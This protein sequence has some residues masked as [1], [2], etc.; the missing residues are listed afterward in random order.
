MMGFGDKNRWL[1]A[2]AT[3]LLCLLPAVV[4]FAAEETADFHQARAEAAYLAGDYARA[5]RFF[6][7]ALSADPSRTWNLHRQALCAVHLEQYDKAEPL[8]RQVLTRADARPDAYFDLG[9]T[10]YHLRRYREALVQFTLARQKGATIETIDYYRGACL[11]RTGQ[12]EAALEAL[13]AAYQALPERRASI[14]YY[15]GACAFAEERYGGAIEYWKEAYE[16]SE[17]GPF[18]TNIERLL[19]RARE[20]HRRTRLWDATVVFGGAWDS[21]V[22]YEPEEFEVADRSGFY[23]F[24]AA[25]LALYALRSR[26]GALGAGYRFY[27]S[28]HVDTRE[29]LLDDYDL[30]RHGLRLEAM[31][32]LGQQSP[33]FLGGEY[34]W[35]RAMLAGDNY[36]ESNAIRPF[37]HLR[38]G[39]AAATRLGLDAEWKSFDEYP[40]R[41]ALYLSPAL[42]QI[43]TFWNQTATLLLEASYENN[44]AETDNYDYRGFG[45]FASLELPLVG[46]LTMLTGL[47]GRYLDYQN[48]VE[49]R[50]DRKYVVDAGLRYHF[51]DWLYSSLGYR[52][53]NNVSLEEFTYEKHV[54]QLDIGFDF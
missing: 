5:Y 20:E 53:Q 46:S 49:E 32:R 47:R 39:A 42:T 33:L 6:E 19:R 3:L 18:R 23:W 34:E 48:N 29:Q 1:I 37:L 16:L 43:F 44:A 17:P 8:L 24:A 54:Y 15:Q 35:S 27:Q 12:Y 10:L 45:G 28:L 22:F 38:E 13:N 14:A 30:T 2:G 9:L 41:D 51:T 7:L 26:N 36:Q 21:N 40:Y 31:S 50:I 4:V 52:F 25:D 11:V